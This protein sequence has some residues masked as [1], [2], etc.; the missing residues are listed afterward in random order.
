MGAAIPSLQA[1][2]L[3]QPSAQVIDGSLKFNETSG[4][5]L[6]RTPSSSGNRRTWTWSCWCKI[7]KLPES[8][9]NGD[10]TL[11]SAVDTSNGGDDDAIRFIRSGITGGQSLYWS[12]SEYNVGDEE[13]IYTN[14]VLRDPN[15]F[16]HVVLIKD[17]TQSSLANGQMRMYI[18]GVEQSLVESNAISQN[19][20]RAINS[21]VPHA[22][23]DHYAQDRPWDGM[24]TQVYLIDGLALGPG[25]FGFTDPL[26]N[27][28]RPKKFKAE[29]TTVN[30]GTVWSSYLTASSGSIQNIANA[31]DGNT[32]TYNNSTTNDVVFTFTPPTP[33]RYKNSVRIWLRTA[34]HKARING[35]TYIFNTGAPLAGQWMTLATGSGLINTIDVQYTANSS[36]AI[37]AIEVDG[38]I[39]RDSTTTNLDFGTNGF[40]LPM[41]G[42]SP[43]GQDK[44]GNGNNW[45]P[46]NFGGSVALD[47]P[48]VSGA[49]PILNTTQG[50]TQAGVGVRTDAYH[51]NLV[52]ALPLI[53]SKDDVSN[54]VNS[55]STTKA[56]TSNG[57][58]VAS[59][60]ASNFYGGSFVFDGSGDYLSSSSSA[61]LTFGTGNFTIECWVYQT[62]AASAED[63]IFQISTTSG[64]LAATQS[65]TITLQTNGSVYRS[66]A[67]NTST[68]FSTAVITNKWVH[69]ALV[70]SSTSLNLFV[71]GVKDATTISDS[72]NYSGTYLAIG[73]Y[74][75]TSY[76]WVGNISDFRV[77]KGVAKYTSNFIP[78]STS[79]DIL[80]DTP[81]GVSGSSKLA[82]ITDGAVT[83][84]GSGDYL[85][86]ANSSDFV[87][88]TGDFTMECY[89]YQKSQGGEATVFGLKHTG[90]SGW[91]GYKFYITTS[92]N[93]ILYAEDAGS[94]DWDIGLQAGNGSVSLNRWHHLSATRNGTTFRV[95][96]DGILKASTTSS[97]DL[98]DG[99]DGF[100]ISNNGANQQ[101]FNGIISNIRIIKGT[102]LYT[103]DFTPPTRTLTNVTNTK[104]L[105]CQSPTSATEGVI[106]PGTITANGDAAATNFNP[107]TT[108]I[109]AVRGQET[110]YATLNPL[111]LPYSASGDTRIST[112]SNGNLTYD[113][114]TS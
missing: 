16:Y 86:L 95:F 5:Y 48:I 3:N 97:V 112:V 35:G 62:S 84:D 31:F 73:G 7:A 100:Y 61:D 34:D 59:N 47:N 2:L 101:Y 41:D 107:F 27:T 99:G 77:Y 72:R 108:D 79:P 114:V 68:P 42:N 19:A 38:V 12:S 8:G 90:G 87:V 94:G 65:D 15:A 96:V 50:G 46:V 92:G 17:T 49:L 113:G 33:I 28:W 75:S 29:G 13:A 23:G 71:N 74:Y 64:G 103:T 81:S 88:G 85:T 26:T 55:G 36:T 104:L 66:Y 102:A 43:I 69:L 53:G 32:T 11:F 60:A 4:S 6:T 25:Y 20:E 105:C 89:I 40:Y 57:D 14:A 39:M 21:Q 10:R 109:N 22:I 58:P 76:L 45:T 18:N 54:S 56:I 67:N 70:R 78:A 91:T 106:K 111:S 1:G 110:G 51:A 24:M 80:P 30:D 9:T 37:N 98:N 83:F 63:G 82:K 93:F 44:S 52:L